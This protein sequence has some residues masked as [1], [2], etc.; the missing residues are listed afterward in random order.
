MNKK[1][2]G[3]APCLFR[4]VGLLNNLEVIKDRKNNTCGEVETYDTAEDTEDGKN[5]D[6]YTCNCVTE[7]VKKNVYDKSAYALLLLKGEGE[8]FL[9]S[10]HMINLLKKDMFFGK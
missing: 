7:N 8:N 9:E 6:N 3:C 5:A 4:L 10:F 2:Q 1:R